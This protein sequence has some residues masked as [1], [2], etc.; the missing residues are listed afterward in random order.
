M[1]RSKNLPDFAIL[2]D[3]AKA[4][5][6][7]ASILVRAPQ[8]ADSICFPIKR[9]SR[10]MMT[11]VLAAIGLKEHVTFH[12]FEWDIS[13]HIDIST[14]TE[15]QSLQRMLIESEARTRLLKEALQN[16]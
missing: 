8:G 16:V 10:A 14:A 1:K 7:M 6:D 4:L 3:V 11:D 5:T 12:P 15:R 13:V 9:E 2:V